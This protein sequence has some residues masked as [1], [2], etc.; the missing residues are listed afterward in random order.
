VS[1][2]IV[3]PRLKRVELI[4]HHCLFDTN[5]NSNLH[6]KE[7][8]Y[9]EA[10]DRYSDAIAVCQASQVSGK[11]LSLLYANRAFAQLRIEAYGAAAA[12]AKV[13]I[14]LDKRNPKAYY[15]LGSAHMALSRYK[16]ALQVFKVVVKLCP[17]DKD[18]RAKHDICK[19]EVDRAAFE[20][21]IAT[22]AT[23]LPSEKT[24]PGE[25]PVPT[26]YSGPRWDGP[27]GPSFAEMDQEV[28]PG[29]RGVGGITPDFVAQAV[30]VGRQVDFEIASLSCTDNGPRGKAVDCLRGRS[31]AVLRLA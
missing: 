2:S 7:G 15:R 3:L 20:A 10:V 9:K 22:E 30:V 8:R 14:D 16:E 31:R 27:D 29:V 25:S 23:L 12:D 28:I 11:A 21:A 17:N 6:F 26:A 5:V 1:F 4:Q 24:N 13:A 19:R 18:A